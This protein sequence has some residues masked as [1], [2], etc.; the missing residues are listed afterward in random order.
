[1]VR[2]SLWLGAALLAAG[3]GEAPQAPVTFSGGV[4]PIVAARC[5]GCH[6][7]GGDAPFSLLTFADVRQRATLIAAVTERR[8]MPPWKPEPGHGSFLGERRLT[9]TEIATIRNWVAGGALEGEPV[10]PPHEATAR[11]WPLGEPD[12]VLTLPA[13][14]LPAEGPDVFRNF[15]VAAPR[16]GG[17]FIRGLHFRPGNPAV[18]HAN[19]RIDPT[20]ASRRLDE[21]DPGPGYEGV[22]LRSADF[23]DGHFLGW[24]PGLAPPEGSRDL[25]WRLPAGA[26]FVVQLHMRPTGAVE[27]IAPAIGLYFSDEPPART[28]VMIRL[29]RQ[30]LEIPAGDSRFRVADDY[31]LSVDVELH[32]IQPHA[33][34]RA[35]AVRAWASLPGGARRELLWISDWDFRWQDQYRYAAP[36]W[37]P[38]GTRI[39]MEYVFDNS[40]SN[41]RNPDRPPRRVEWGWRTS[42]EMADVWMQVITR[43]ASD[44]ARLLAD[45]RPKMLEEDAAGS[46]VLVARSPAHVSLRNDAALIYMALGRPARALEHFEAASSLEPRSAAGR[47]NVGVALDALGRK[48]EA[49]RAYREAVLLNPAHSG[50]HNNLGNLL[51]AAGRH[52][53][54]RQQYARAAEADPSN[55]EAQRNLGAVL[56]ASGEAERAAAHFAEAIRLRPEWPPALVAL[57]WVRAASEDPAA[58]RPG[59]AVDLAERAAALAPEDASVLDVLAASYASAGR[60]EAAIGVATRAEAAAVSTGQSRLLEAIRDRLARFRR[61]EAFV[62]K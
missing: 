23:P 20:P 42:D 12:A 7:P 34:V 45:V 30:R 44:R 8:T 51:L 32:A 14:A 28:P 17:G 59:E 6:R 22:I 62:M 53:E 33:H 9:D 10:E 50:A 4:A 24:T 25:S 43:S 56:M 31:R 26:D 60:F 39:Q 58:R 1:M 54:A 5:V 48:A 49:E 16:G 15:V 38:A 47:Y 41:V 29:G 11:S 21:E 3:A 36:L 13:F 52:E 2:A 61:G 57:A 55:A 27:T 46:E 19:I 35:R 40:A 18:H 37:L